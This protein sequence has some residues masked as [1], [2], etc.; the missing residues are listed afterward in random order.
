[1]Q[2][3]N[4]PLT[5]SLIVAILYAL[6]L[7]IPLSRN[8][9]DFSI[10]VNAGDRF[11]DAALAPPN[12]SI[13]PNS[14]GYDG[15]FYYR[16]AL[17]PF[18]DRQTDR[19][20]TIDTPAYRQQRIVYPLLAR[21]LSLGRPAA[22]PAAL[23][24]VNL[25]G[26]CGI[27]YLGATYAQGAGRNALWGVALALYP[28]FLMTLSRD[29]VEIVAAFFLIAFIVAMQRERSFLAGTCLALAVLAKETT[30]LAAA[31]VG[32][33][34]VIE[35]IRT[36]QLRPFDRW[37]PALLPPVAYVLWQ[38]WL[39]NT[40]R[41]ASV[42]GHT[43]TNNI[44]LP[45]AGLIGFGRA[46][47]PPP[48]HVERVWLVEVALLALFIGAC[49]LALRRS[50]AEP[51]VKVG[52]LLFLALAVSLT[53]TVW[54]ED[55]AYL[56]VLAEV[57]LFGAVILLASESPLRRAVLVVAPT[58]WVLLAVDLLYLR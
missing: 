28:G 35:T 44:G 46:L 42:T 1:M 26:L 18:T 17:T 48:G 53:R 50:A 45:F 41:M 29:T 24:L 11:V 8:D 55:W 16:L 23:V 52:W 20:I 31:A 2:R 47:W 5:A 25:L 40:W 14:D 30:L 58:V 34:A 57:Y 13:L 19:G 3:L 51:H 21:L 6:F 54:V 56:R 22:V 7:F 27:A 10:F 4:N 9:Y 38:L 32:I 43:F 39:A 37:L 36:R 12:L 15:Q 49:L 33:V